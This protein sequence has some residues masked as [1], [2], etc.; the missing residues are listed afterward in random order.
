MGFFYKK[1][2]QPKTTKFNLYLGQTICCEKIIGY[3]NLKLHQ[4]TASKAN[5]SQLIQIP[6]C[7]V[8]HIQDVVDTIFDNK[9]INEIEVEHVSF[10]F[11]RFA[12]IWTG[13]I[14]IVG[15]ILLWFNCII[16]CGY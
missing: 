10:Y 3:K 4:T 11:K 2:Y 13:I 8:H 1:K 7:K 5:K 9:D 12:M 16:K 14:T 15:L 6:G